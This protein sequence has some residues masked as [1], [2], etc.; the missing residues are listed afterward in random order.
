MSNFATIEGSSSIGGA[1]VSLL[2]GGVLNNGSATD[3]AALI[4]GFMGV[5]TAAK[6]TNFGTIEGGATTGA[7][8]VYMDGGSLTEEAGSVIEGYS[9]LKMQG[10]TATVFGDITPGS[11]NAVGLYGAS[12]LDL[13]AGSTISGN[14]VFNGSGVIDVVSGV[15]TVKAISTRRAVIGAGTLNLADGYLGIGAALDCAVV[16]QTASTGKLA[17]YANVVDSHHWY[18]DAGATLYVGA[19]DKMSFT[20]VR[21]S[22]AGTV[23]GAGALGLNAGYDTLSNATLSVAQTSIG[24]S[25][26]VTM[27][28]AIDIAG[29]VTSASHIV[30]IGA[31]GVTLTGGGVVTLTGASQFYG[32]SSAP[33][34]TNED[35]IRVRRPAQ[36]PGPGQ[37]R[38][39]RRQQR[40]APGPRRLRR[41]DEFRPVRSHR[42]R[43][44]DDH[45]NRI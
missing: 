3:H 36:Q 30:R 34:F 11:G 2:S 12:R 25:T 4:R 15:A 33:T 23:S 5:D 38:N 13:E 39:D 21:N 7:W 19:G 31:S 27:I 44:S 35:T 29:A 16:H 22:F 8:G 32:F 14:V 28:G 40:D 45:R 26:T 18:Q 9:G 1:G 6:V 10:A 41:D 17:V 24:A 20:S 42:R 37:P 43:A